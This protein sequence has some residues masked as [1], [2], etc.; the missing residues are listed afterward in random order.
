ME[1]TEVIAQQ[2]QKF[3]RMRA[4]GYPVHEQTT[5]TQLA[6]FKIDALTIDKGIPIPVSASTY[7]Q[8]TPLFGR[9]DVGDSV[10]LPTGKLIADLMRTASYQYKKKVLPTFK[11][12]FVQTEEGFR[13]WRVA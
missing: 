3:D 12:Q 6:T 8:W 13:V 5:S 4:D 10:F 7:L 2:V 11:L 9:M 1:A